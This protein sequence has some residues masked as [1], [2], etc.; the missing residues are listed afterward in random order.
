M[1]ANFS[2]S[3][4]PKVQSSYFLPA[5]HPKASLEIELLLCCA[6]S[7]ISAATAEQIKS[8]VHKEIDWQYFFQQATQHSVVPLAYQS[9]NA[10]CPEAVPQEILTLLHNQFR[11]NARRNLY[12]AREL[13][14]LLNLFN[15]HN[16]PVLCFKGPPLTVSCYG[17]LSLRQFSDLDIL[18][19][20]QDLP[21]ARDLLLSQGARVRF[22]VVNLTENEK[23][24]FVQSETVHKFV[25]ECAYEMEYKEGRVV[26]E[27]H[28]QVMPHYFCFPL[29][30]EYL[31]QRLKATTLLGQTISNLSPEDS[32]LLLCGH[33]AKDCWDKLARICDIAELLGTYPS[34]D[35]KWVIEQASSRGG[36]RILLQGLLLAHDLLGTFLPEIVWQK[37]KHDPTTKILAKQVQQGLFCKAKEQPG[38]F[39][40]FLFHLRIKNRFWD[41]V[42]YCFNVALTP[43]FSDWTLLPRVS[44]PQVFYYLLRPIRLLGNHGLHL[45]FPQSKSHFLVERR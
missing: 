4:L 35:W 34:L 23:A 2:T 42:R 17:D 1:V 22:H 31:W 30:P 9:L 45:L 20:E 28:W 25:R 11:I 10:I 33:G 38:Q 18:V 5:T 14:Q 13:L 36:E 32:L 7:Q 19:S 8:L 21:R 15:V 44:F 39:E 40:Q 16:I 37:I 43:T 27:L 3:M 6:R 24:T 12:L 26:L 29:K 41:R